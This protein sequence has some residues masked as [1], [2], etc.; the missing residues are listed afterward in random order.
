MALPRAAG[1]YVWVTWLSKLLLGSLG[2]KDPR[3]P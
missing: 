1:P 3:R 2:G